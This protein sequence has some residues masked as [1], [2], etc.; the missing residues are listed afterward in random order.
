MKIEKEKEM[1]G[2]FTVLAK[3]ATME[4]H[5]KAM[6]NLVFKDADVEK[7]WLAQWLVVIGR[8]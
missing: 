2:T 5:G 4:H 1:S 8:W 6:Y 7:G 3:V